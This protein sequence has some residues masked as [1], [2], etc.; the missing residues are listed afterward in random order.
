[1]LGQEPR[2]VCRTVLEHA[3]SADGLTDSGDVQGQRFAAGQDKIN[4][5]R[6]RNTKLA[7]AMRAQ[8]EPIGVAGGTGGT[9][10]RPSSLQPLE[11]ALDSLRSSSEAQAQLLRQVDERLVEDAGRLLAELMAVR[12]EMTQQLGQLCSSA[13]Q[14]VDHVEALASQAQVL[15]GELRSSLGLAN[16]CEQ[17]GATRARSVLASVEQLDSS[18]G[19]R[20]QQGLH[21]AQELCIATASKAVALLDSQASGVGQLCQGLESVSVGVSGMQEACSALRGRCGDATEKMS[22]LRQGSSDA[23]RQL[24]AGLASQAELDALSAE[25]EKHRS[26]GRASEN[27][28]RAWAEE[29]RN[30]LVEVKRLT[31]LVVEGRTS[32]A[33]DRPSGEQ[34]FSPATAQRRARSVQSGAQAKRPLI[35][36]E[37][38]AARL[39]RS[40]QAVAQA[41][42]P[43]NPQVG[44]PAK[45][46]SAHNAAR[47]AALAG[48]H[49]GISAL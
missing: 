40:A 13:D 4:A 14:Q 21:E 32:Q 48:S 45:A 35:T 20:A 49:L 42:R 26:R 29:R 34:G 19:K 22:A 16:T 27:A 18:C 41:G 7:L 36:Q 6:E 8:N 31:D 44:A 28:E 46:A 38:S 10:Q 12:T 5:I 11:E 33:T 39:G 24:I 1:M 17:A 43:P 2:R 3:L 15:H 9:G 30:L 37:A 25:L 23:M 47:L